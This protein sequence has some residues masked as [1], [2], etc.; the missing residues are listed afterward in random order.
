MIKTLAIFPYRR[1]MTF[2]TNLQIKKEEL[3]IAEKM[4]IKR[5]RYYR[6]RNL[7]SKKWG[8]GL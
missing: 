1:S 4:G 6:R 5:N 3:E 7:Q 8:P 2:A